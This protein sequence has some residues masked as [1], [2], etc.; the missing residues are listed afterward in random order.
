MTEV[1]PK[2]STPV[3]DPHLAAFKNSSIYENF[4]E[5]TSTTLKS[6]IIYL[7]FRYLQTLLVNMRFL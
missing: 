6:V 3:Q 7:I 1:K 2:T 4:G 5:P